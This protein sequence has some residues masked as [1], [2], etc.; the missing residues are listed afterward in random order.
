MGLIDHYHNVATITQRLIAIGKLLH[1]SKNDAIRLSA[2]KE[3]FKV[4]STLSLNRSLAQKCG[5][6]AKLAK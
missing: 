4:L 2:N 3:G 1:R 6:T 5:A